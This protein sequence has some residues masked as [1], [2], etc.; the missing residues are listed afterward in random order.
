MIKSGLVT[1]V[2]VGLGFLFPWQSAGEPLKD[3]AS[4]GP[5]DNEPLL[6]M[7]DNELSNEESHRTLSRHKRGLIYLPN[8]T[9]WSLT[10][11][12]KIPLSSEASITVKV[13]VKYVFDGWCDCT[14]CSCDTKSSSRDLR[15]QLSILNVVETTMGKMGLDG[16]TC[17][18]RAVCEINETPISQFSFIGEIVTLLLTLKKEHKERNFL[19]DYLEAET[20]GARGKDLCWKK[21]ST[22]PISIL[23]LHSQFKNSASVESNAIEGAR[24]QKSSG[25]PIR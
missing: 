15:H 13:P 7:I 3:W 19:K 14:G 21:Y 18:L 23:T 10:S 2:V 4:L 1:L 22:C 6:A 16:R 25:K 5:V 8:G 20:L 17:V 12:L 11:E 9:E 24:N